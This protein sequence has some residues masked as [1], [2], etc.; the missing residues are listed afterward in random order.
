MGKNKM[1][2]AD[3]NKALKFDSTNALAHF[4]KAVLYEG[5]MEIEKA[6]IHYTKAISLDNDF[7]KAYN[8][9]GVLKGMHYE[10]FEGAYEDFD[11]ALAVNPQ[12]HEALGN[13]VFTNLLL[14]DTAAACSYMQELER[15]GVDMTAHPLKPYC[16]SR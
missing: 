5:N 2:L 11:K 7:Y 1:A 16:D 14:A 9:R 12:M 8:A 6:I 13:M 10:D 15:L 4:N 3:F